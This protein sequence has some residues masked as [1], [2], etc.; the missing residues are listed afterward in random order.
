[1]RIPNSNLAEAVDVAIDNGSVQD[2]L[3]VL[4]ANGFTKEEAE[5]YLLKPAFEYIDGEFVPLREEENF[6]EFAPIDLARG[7]DSYV[8]TTDVELREAVV[9]PADAKPTLIQRLF[10]K[11]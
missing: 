11:G 7:R 3:N 6:R 9:V 2:G 5:E 10:G 1:M 8:A 4:T